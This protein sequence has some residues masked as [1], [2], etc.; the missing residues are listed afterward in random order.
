MVTIVLK[1]AFGADGRLV[2]VS[3]GID[4]SNQGDLNIDLDFRIPGNPET[5]AL[6]SIWERLV[7]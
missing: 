7:V 5:Q 1:M 4:T 6:G 2:S 3:D